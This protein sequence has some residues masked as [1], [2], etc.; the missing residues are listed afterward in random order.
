MLEACV[1][2]FIG[3]ML[4]ILLGNGVVAGVVL[5]KT[6]SQNSGWIVITFAWGLAVF[7]GVLVAGPISGAHLNPAVT[8][9]LALAGKFSWAWVVPF[10]VSQ[11]L[12]AMLGQLLVWG[13]YYPHYSATDDVDLKLA[14]CCTSPAIKSIPSN[15][16]SEIIGTFVLIFAILTMHGVVVHSGSSSLTTAY[17]VDMGALGGI[18]VAF[19]VIAVGMS[20]GGTTGYA[21][22]PARDFGPRLFHAI[23]PIQGKGSSQWS[24]AWIPILGP[25]IGSAIATALYLMLKTKGVF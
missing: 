3:T 13:M 14:T 7:I 20:L 11:I 1:A 18:P 5:N 12:G 17:P 19:V 6:K 24:Y 15:L 25:V 10:I 2:E 21:I 8:L 9:A 23:M 22:N 16:M 4:L